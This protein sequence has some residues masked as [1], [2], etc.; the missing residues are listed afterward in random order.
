MQVKMK[1]MSLALG[2]GLAASSTGFAQAPAQQKIGIAGIQQAIAGTEEGKKEFAALQTRFTP[3]QNELKALNDEVEK[4]KTQLQA[5]S[6]KLSEEARA[7]QV[8]TLE[9]KQK[10]LQRNYEDYQAEAQQAQQEVVNR[11][12][13]KMLK[14]LDTYAKTNGYSVILDVSNPQSTPVLFASETTKQ[15]LRLSTGIIAL[16]ITFSKDF[17]HQVPA[18]AVTFLVWAWLAYLLS[19]LFGIWTLM[20]LTGTLQPKADAA[21]PPRIW[22]SNVTRPASFQ[23][24]SFLVGLA[25]TICFGISS[26][27]PL[28]PFC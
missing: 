7:T 14:V 6:D 24:L 4:L 25:L 1:V 10:Q 8:K 23:I 17:V 26:L 2:L 27:C 11:L 16:T 18:K 12:G 15:I 3:K 22:G 21:N 5:Q 13:E 19:I 28:W 9:T 20:A